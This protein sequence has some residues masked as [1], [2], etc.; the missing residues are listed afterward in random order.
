M[1]RQAYKAP[2]PQAARNTLKIFSRCTAAAA[3]DDKGCPVYCQVSDTACKAAPIAVAA[4]PRRARSV[5]QHVKAW[6]IGQATNEVK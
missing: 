4:M 6:H 2:R 3:E 5:V 1:Q